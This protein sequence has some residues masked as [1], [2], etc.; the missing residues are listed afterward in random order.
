MKEKILLNSLVV[1]M[2]QKRE[3]ASMLHYGCESVRASE[4]RAA[5]KVVYSENGKTLQKVL[6]QKLFILH[7]RRHI[8]SSFFFLIISFDLFWIVLEPCRRLP[9]H[10]VSSLDCL[11]CTQNE[12]LDFWKWKIW[13]N[14]FQPYRDRRTIVIAIKIKI[15]AQ[16]WHEHIYGCVHHICADFKSVPPVSL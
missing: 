15:I 13:F 3:R 7:C 10:N 5:V 9:F 8:S 2:C 14:N 11:P 4:M 12:T 16:N 1:W 6:I